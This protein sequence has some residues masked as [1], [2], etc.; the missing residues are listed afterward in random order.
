M[1]ILGNASL[2][3]NVFYHWSLNVCLLLDKGDVSVGCHDLND[4]IYY[5]LFGDIS[6][7]VPACIW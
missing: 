2:L 3:F 5:S 1:L 7:H 4:L 6:E